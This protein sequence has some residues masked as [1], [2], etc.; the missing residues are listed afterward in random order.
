MGASGE[1]PM[2]GYTAEG[3]ACRSCAGC[4]ASLEVEGGSAQEGDDITTQPLKDELFP[5]RL[6]LA[7]APGRGGD[8]GLPERTEGRTEVPV[9]LT[10]N[11]PRQ[12]LTHVQL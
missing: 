12:G 7:P 4:R 10:P 5:Q 8:I 3:K 9:R 11:K 2:L 6:Q 1:V